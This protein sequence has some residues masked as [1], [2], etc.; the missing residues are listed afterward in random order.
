MWP[1]PFLRNFGPQNPVLV[2]D[3][4]LVGGREKTRVVIPVPCTLF[5]D[6]G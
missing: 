2:P 1:H 5:S 3:E 6:A 4:A